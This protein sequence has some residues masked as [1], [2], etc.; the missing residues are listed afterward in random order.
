MALI[1][2]FPHTDPTG[3]AGWRAFG[4]VEDLDHDFRA[5]DRPALVT[6]VLAAC[7]A[8]P[9]AH[10]AVWDMTLAA[11]LGGLLAILAATDPRRQLSLTRHC[12]RATCGEAMDIDLPTRELIALA[13][14]AGERAE[15]DCRGRRLRR[16][17]G[18]D[19]RRWRQARFTSRAEAEAAVLASLVAGGPVT[20]EERA[21]LAEAL[22]ELDPLSAFEVAVTCPECGHAVG[23]PVDL[24]AVVLGELARHQAQMIAD[25][26][27]LARRYGWSESQVLA[28][29]AWRRKQYLAL[30]GEGRP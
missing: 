30:D 12:P 23:I 1:S 13:R 17:C 27:R 6:A 16:P 25:V 20:A 22:A 10:E 2:R 19:Q 9:I 7:A 15:A 5:A 24:E 8:P 3:S 29:P 21:V 4:R 11:R 18:S 28:V 14:S 26:D